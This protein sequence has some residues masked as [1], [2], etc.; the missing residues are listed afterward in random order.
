MKDLN[1]EYAE[2]LAKKKAASPEY[3]KI[4]EDAQ[5]LLIAKMNIESF[6][7]AEQKDSHERQS[8]EKQH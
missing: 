7:E 4:K 8:Q 2:L 1:S 5:E 6:Y 3:R